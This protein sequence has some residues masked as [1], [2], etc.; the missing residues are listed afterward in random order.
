MGTGARY[1]RQP[2]LTVRRV[3]RLQRL[4]RR[5]RVRPQVGGREAD[6]AA[7]YT[8][9]GEP[10]DH[11]G[12][13]VGG[14]GQRDEQVAAQQEH[15][16]RGEYAGPLQSFQFLRTSWEERGN[17]GQRFEFS[18]WGL[19]G[20]LQPTGWLRLELDGTFGGELDYANVR[21][22]DRFY[23]KPMVDL[24]LGHHLSLDLSHLVDRLD[25]DD[26]WPFTAN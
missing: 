2:A 15:E 12:D 18:S 16:L 24:F 8:F 9:W 23:L 5:L 3:R 13:R 14:A 17:R 10:G 19:F 1:E 4:P 7:D 25:V 6:T 26:G 21:E 22:G 11:T 20:R